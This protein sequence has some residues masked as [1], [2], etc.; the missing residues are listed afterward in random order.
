MI[1]T[2]EESMLRQLN[3]MKEML[4]FWKNKQKETRDQKLIEK[5]DREM[6]KE[7]HRINQT[8]EAIIDYRRSNENN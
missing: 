1:L 8:T 6:F 7:Q 5:C 3:E 2:M 4:L